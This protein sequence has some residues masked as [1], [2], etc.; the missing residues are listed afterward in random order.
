MAKFAKNLLISPWCS[1]SVSQSLN[2]KLSQSLIY[3][4]VEVFVAPLYKTLDM[5]HCSALVALKDSDFSGLPL[6]HRRA[7]SR[8]SFT[9]KWAFTNTS[10]I[11]FMNKINKI[12]PYLYKL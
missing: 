12:K 10:V 7:I 4:S 9:E 8:Y 1:Q 3:K 6:R 11:E 5:T 2:Q